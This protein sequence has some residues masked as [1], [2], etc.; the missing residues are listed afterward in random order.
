MELSLEETSL[1]FEMYKEEPDEEV[2]GEI[3]DAIGA[4]RRTYNSTI[5]YVTKRSS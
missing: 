4:L 3:V 1:L 2:H 5:K